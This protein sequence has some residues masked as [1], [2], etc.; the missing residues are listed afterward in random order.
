MLT[1]LRYHVGESMLPSF[2]DYLK[3]IDLHFRFDAHGFTIKNEAAFKMNPQNR[4]GC[5]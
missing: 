1:C 3:F 2:W 4:E 5:K